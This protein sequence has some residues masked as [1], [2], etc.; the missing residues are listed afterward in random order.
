[1]IVTNASHEE[2]V[3]L[4]KQIMVNQMMGHLQTLAVVKHWM[5]ACQ[6]FP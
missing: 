1:M 2:F 5:F 4:F 3:K 6:T